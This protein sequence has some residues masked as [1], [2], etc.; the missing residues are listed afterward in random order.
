[1][2]ARSSRICTEVQANLPSYVDRSL[3]V[4]RRRLVGLHLRR[5]A[6]CQAQ[7]ARQRPIP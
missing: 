3:P 6:D 2:S 5:C 7:F 4:L 1:M